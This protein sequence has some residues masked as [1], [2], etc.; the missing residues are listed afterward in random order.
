MTSQS[1]SFDRAVG[2]YDQTRGLNE[3]IATHGIQAIFDQVGAHAA[4]LEV[5]AG[6]GRIGVPLL[7]RGANWIGCDLSMEMMRKLREKLPQ[8]RLAQSDATR[9]SFPAERFDAVLTIHV[10]HLVG[11]WRTALREYR[12]VLKPGGMY[13]N[14]W[15]WHAVTSISHR[16]REYWRRRVEAYGADWRRP[17]AQDNDEVVDELKSMGAQVDRREVVRGISQTSPRESIDGLAQRFQSDTWN[18]PD[19]ILSTTVQELR[20]WATIELGVLDQALDEEYRFML[21]VARF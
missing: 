3:S 14:S 5:G 20:E 10:M 17:G 1:L 16:L 11:A 12:R 7:Q 8:A 6:T 21:D 2:F 4:V 9:L 19:D 18:I 15:H 13:I